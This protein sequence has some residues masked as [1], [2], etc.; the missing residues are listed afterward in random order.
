MRRSSGIASRC[1]PAPPSRTLLESLPAGRSQ[2]ASLRRRRTELVLRR[3]H[4]AGPAAMARE[5]L[6]EFA[7][8]LLGAAAVAL[9]LAAWLGEMYLGGFVDRI[10]PLPGLAGPL[11]VALAAIVLVLVAAAARHLRLALALQPAEALG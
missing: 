6:R 3:L 2:S 1:E 8:P 7:G 9:P 5:V 4:G 10:D 11:S